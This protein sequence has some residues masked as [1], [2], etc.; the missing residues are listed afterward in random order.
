MPT[1]RLYRHPLI[2]CDDRKKLEYVLPNTSMSDGKGS[3]R[4][5]DSDVLR[6]VRTQDHAS[7]KGVAEEL[8]CTRQTAHYR[9]NQLQSEGRVESEQIGNTLIWSVVE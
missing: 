9:L 8:G 2:V 3:H 7:A 6:A 5:D 4:Y 1:T